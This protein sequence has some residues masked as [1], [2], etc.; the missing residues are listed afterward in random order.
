MAARC[1]H[2]SVRLPV[3]PSTSHP[4][5]GAVI[6]V[7]VEDDCARPESVASLTGRTSLSVRPLSTDLTGTDEPPL[8]E[9]PAIHVGNDRPSGAPGRASPTDQPS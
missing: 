4:A 2:R 1:G 9:R 8:R 3:H 5:D 7:F 6:D